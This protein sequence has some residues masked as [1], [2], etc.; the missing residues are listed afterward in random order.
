MAVLGADDLF[1]SDECSQDVFSLWSDAWSVGDPVNM[2]EMV[3]DDF[4]DM[5]PL[6]P[7][8]SDEHY[9]AGWL[10][11]ASPDV[12][13]GYISPPQ[14]GLSSRGAAEL[15]VRTD[16]SDY[17]L[18]PTDNGHHSI[19]SSGVMAPCCSFVDSSVQADGDNF[20]EAVDE[21]AYELNNCPHTDSLDIPEMMVVSDDE[22]GNSKD[23]DNKI[24]ETS[25]SVSELTSPRPH[26]IAARRAEIALAKEGSSDDDDDDYDYHDDEVAHSRVRSCEVTS[27]QRGR[28]RVPEVNRN[29]LNARINRQKKKA[30]MASLEAQKDR[31]SDENK[32]MKLTMSRLMR[33][34][35]NL[36]EEVSYLKSVLAN[37]SVLA[38]LVQNINGP[39]LKLSS[40]FDRAAQKRNDVESDH[41]YGPPRKLKATTSSAAV[42]GGICLH[43]NENQLSLELC[44]RCASMAGGDRSSGSDS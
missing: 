3:D 15:T 17:V 36:A 41:N 2:P 43:V 37:D 1:L 30:Y 35:N 7:F 13:A 34:R 24:E 14:S 38:K 20:P 25:D 39:P 4:D 9:D 28:K 12:I 26:R 16:Y 19:T 6:A 40:R 44:H 42:V 8:Q 32:H 5:F 33:E 29:A 21:R 23:M 18:S 31:L 27:S 11:E 10:S 22:P